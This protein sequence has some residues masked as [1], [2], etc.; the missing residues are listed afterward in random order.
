MTSVTYSQHQLST[1]FHYNLLPTGAQ[2]LFTHPVPWFSLYH[3]IR[4]R[5]CFVSSDDGDINE[6]G[7]EYIGYIMSAV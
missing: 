7:G 2:G 5:E 1:T 4:Q 3:V 6:R